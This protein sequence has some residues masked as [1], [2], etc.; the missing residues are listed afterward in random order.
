MTTYELSNPIT[1]IINDCTTMGNYPD[2]FKKN[3]IVPVFKSKDS[4]N[5]MSHNE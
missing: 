1:R 4:F 2:V 3:E 5:K